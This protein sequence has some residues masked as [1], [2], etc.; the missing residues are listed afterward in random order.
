MTVDRGRRGGERDFTVEFGEERDFTTKVT[1]FTKEEI[2]HRR[3]A[4]RLRSGQAPIAEFGETRDF[5]TKRTKFTKE[6]K[7]KVLPQRRPSTS[8]RTGSDR[9]VKNFTTKHTK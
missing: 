3:G 7:K 2:I 6:E 4:L 8:L 1:K 9:R 5:A